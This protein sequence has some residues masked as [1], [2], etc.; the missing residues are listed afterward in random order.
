M[1]QGEEWLQL[2]SCDADYEL[3]LQ[4]EFRAKLFE[5]IVNLFLPVPPFLFTEVS[6]Y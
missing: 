2:I 6:L 1:L 5:F 3:P 4:K